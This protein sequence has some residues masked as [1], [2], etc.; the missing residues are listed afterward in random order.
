ME[1]SLNKEKADA[2]TLKQLVEMVVVP[3][4]LRIKRLRTDMGGEY[5]A[6]YLKRYCL[7]TATAYEYAATNIPQ[8]KQVSEQA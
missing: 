4:G 7:H 5:T 1:R 2:N 3:R 6:G 8:Q